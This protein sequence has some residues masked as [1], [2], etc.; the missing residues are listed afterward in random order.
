MKRTFG[1]TCQHRELYFHSECDKHDEHVQYFVWLRAELGGTSN[2]T[3]C[4]SSWPELPAVC[5]VCNH[6]AIHRSWKLGVLHV[7]NYEPTTRTP[8][9]RSTP[10]TSVPT[11]SPST[12]SPTSAHDVVGHHS[13]ALDALSLEQRPLRSPLQQV[14]NSLAGDRVCSERPCAPGCCW[15]CSL[16]R[17]SSQRSIKL[18]ATRLFSCHSCLHFISFF[19]CMRFLRSKT[20]FSISSEEEVN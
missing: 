18:L 5:S 4:K 10:T 7:S 19:V 9:I 13:G 11:S 20:L 3:S 6:S 1:K 14:D 8:N 2:V 15:C 12:A 17:E 16:G